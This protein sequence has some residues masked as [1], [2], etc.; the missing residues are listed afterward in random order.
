MTDTGTGRHG[1]PERPS[2]DGLE[3]KWAPRWQEEGTYAFDRSKERADVYAIDTPPPTVSGSLHIGH[4][5][6]YTHTD[7]V[8]RFQRMRG[9]AVF[10]PMGFDDNGLPTERR[11]QNLFGVRC[12][13][14]LPYDPSWEPPAK[15]PKD[16]VSISRRNFVE[17][18]GRL[19]VEDEK[20]FEALWR[21]LG[22]S[23]DW[24]LTYTTIGE[25]ARAVSQRAFLANLA[26]GQAYTAEAPTLWDIGFRTAVAQ[27]ELEDRERPGAYHRLRF[28]GP[29]GPVEIDTT[30]PEL[31]PACVALVHHPGDP[32]FAGLTSVRTPFFDVEVPVR[33]HPLAAADKGTGIAMV[34]TFGDLADVTWW[35]D[36]ALETRVVLGRDGRFLPDAPAGVPVA[37]YQGL[38]GLTVNAARAEMVRVLRESGDLLGEP[39]PITHPVKFYERGDRPLEIV[40]SRQWF[41][42][43]GGRDPRLREELLERGRELRWVPESMRHRYEHWVGGLT[44]DWLVSR[45]RF[46]GVAIPVW[47]PLDANGEPDY[48]RPLLPDDAALPVDPSSD[49]PPGWSAEQRDVPGGF[50]ADPDVMD[51]WATS[52]LS[53]QIVTGWSTDPDLHARTYPMDLRPQ[54]QEIIRTWLFSSVL[55]AGQLTGGLPWRRT[56][57]NGWI[58]DPNHK[59]ISKSQGNAVETPIQLL[60]QYGSDAVRYWAACG[61]PGADL[62]FEPA[63]LKV[64]R[65]LAMKLLNASRFALGLGAADALRQPVTE[66]LDRAMLGRLAEMVVTATAAFDDYQHT[67]ALQAT[68]TFFW[69]FCDDYIELVKNRAYA[70]GPGGD[71]ARAALAT[72]LSVLVRL[73]AP[74]LPFVTEEIWSWW[75]YGSVHRSTWPTRYELSRVAPESDPSLLD[76]AGEALRQVRRAKSDRKLS[77]KTDVPLAE[78]LGPADLLDRLESIDGDFRA[79][80]RIGKLDLLRDRTPE[81]VIACAF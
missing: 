43:N 24:G 38:A 4:V 3:E 28:H 56:V 27:A 60:E 39:S 34:C 76:L 5:F 48:E 81:L 14:S 71:S 70:E 20:G 1:L 15:A 37:A 40:T 68:E 64:G 25:K 23:V 62:A 78:A 57:L 29:E 69:T 16:A 26:A 67:D 8:A 58:L 32:R 72:G 73:F 45:Q 30:R 50:T 2:L 36:L 53:P 21:R 35:R 52:S 11:V 49:C 22:L 17:L 54:G 65:R 74:F 10:Y 75:R 31:L 42:R 63:Q 46:F 19:T 59:K 33:A 80:A 7:T 51:T 6:S 13:P 9:K 12:D 44:G 66:P 41:I 18:C 55:R 77:M 79:A 61:R 47:Y